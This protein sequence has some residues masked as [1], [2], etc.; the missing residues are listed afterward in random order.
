MTPVMPYSGLLHD[1]IEQSV[2]QALSEIP[3]TG[4]TIAIFHC[5][6][7]YR[8][9]LPRSVILQS[10]EVHRE[11]FKQPYAVCHEMRYET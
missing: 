1:T 10:H 9:I 7:S 2:D 3:L 4:D 6:P 8:A 5:S 11:H